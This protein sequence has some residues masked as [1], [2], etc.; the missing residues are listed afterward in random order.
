[1]A[2]KGVRVCLTLGFPAKVES[3]P[4]V[5]RTVHYE[6]QSA[7]KAKIVDFVA[8]DRSRHLLARISR[9]ASHA[10]A[11]GIL[12]WLS[13]REVDSY[14]ASNENVGLVLLTI[15]KYTG[16]KRRLIIVNHH[17]SHKWKSRIFKWLGLRTVPATLVCLNQ[18]QAEHALKK[19]RVPQDRVI[20]IVY[21]GG[22]DDRFFRDTSTTQPRGSYILSVGREKRDYQTLVSAL[23]GLEIPLI[24]VASG[25]RR[26]ELYSGSVPAISDYV[27]V[28]KDLTFAQLR[29]L[30]AGASFVVLPLEDV[31][32]PAGITVLMEAMAMG[33]A[34]IATRSRGISGIFADGVDGI[35]VAPNDTAGFR[36][37]L[38]R[39]WNTPSIADE[40]GAEARRAMAGRF[41]FDNYVEKLISLLCHR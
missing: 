34:V 9:I 20:P 38:L 41:N 28:K 22:V 37:A 39:L 29:D 5:P 35:W 27:T 19:L 36:N 7:L 25:L 40:I 4:N 31:E 2:G 30:Y 14:Y 13:R 8:V 12:A 16:T 11:A 26:H 21:G 1:M 10:F 3:A 23:R 18:L 32:F 6:L 15:F 33:K 17:L 24:V